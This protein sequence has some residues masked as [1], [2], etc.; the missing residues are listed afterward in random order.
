MIYEINDDIRIRVCDSQTFFINIKTN[1]LSSM[2]TNSYMYFKSKLD[3][4]L[5][6]TIFDNENDKFNVFISE[7]IRNGVIVKN[8]H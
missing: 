1:E 5:T 8:D 7:L 2:N 4:G 6:D 3:S